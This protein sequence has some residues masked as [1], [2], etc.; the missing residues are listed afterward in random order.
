[1]PKPIE[2]YFDFSS[3]Y[4]YIS[5]EQ[6]E[7]VAARH[8]RAVDYKPV[9][10]GAVFKT[11][12]GAPLT[13][14]YRPKAN[15]AKRDFERSARYSGVA[16]RQP[17]RFPIASLAAKR[18]VVWLQQHQPAVVAPFIH[19]VYRAFFVDDRDISDS[20]VVGEIAREVGIDP[21]ELAAGAQHPETKQRLKTLV[22]HA[23]Q[24]GIFGA[25]TIIVDGEV[26]W[27]NDRMPQIERWL[28]K[29]SF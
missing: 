27:G 13:E 15:Y 4:S 5:S 11:S 23:I 6:I 8:G 17:T 25:P 7:S 20:T 2:F 9:L 24:S 16:Y 26:F 28:E 12:G 10:L 1:M 18:S 19:A 21:V 29:G 3:P 14:L 22:D